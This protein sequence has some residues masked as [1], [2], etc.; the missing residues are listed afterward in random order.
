MFAYLRQLT[1]VIVAFAMLAACAPI[2]PSIVAMEYDQVYNFRQY[3]FD[4][5]LR[6][7]STTTENG[8]IGFYPG[9]PQVAGFWVAYIICAIDNQAPDAQAFT[10]DLSKFYVIYEGR[11]HYWRPLDPYT[12]ATLPNWFATPDAATAVNTQFASELEQGPL[13]RVIPK[14]FSNAVPLNYRLLI[15]VTKAPP[16][17]PDSTGSTVDLSETI[18]LRY[19][20][21]PNL[22]RSRNQPPLFNR[23]MPQQG[24]I[25]RMCRPRIVVPPVNVP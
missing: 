19:D 23:L 24:D 8:A 5:Y 3:Q 7:G 18:P 10:Y 11:R 25:P 16:G 4:Q 2:T 9:V 13:T 21:A 15:Y 6:I 14:G 17:S 1:L 22:L 20:G 12:F